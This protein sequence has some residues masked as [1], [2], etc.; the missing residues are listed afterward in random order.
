MK[1]RKFWII[2]T[3]NGAQP[4]GNLKC[5]FPQ[6]NGLCDR[7][8]AAYRHNEKAIRELGNDRFEHNRER[9][10]STN[11]AIKDVLKV[12]DKSELIKVLHGPMHREVNAL[13]Q[14]MVS[15]IN[16][17]GEVAECGEALPEVI[18][19]TYALAK[20]TMEVADGSQKEAIKKA[21]DKFDKDF[22]T[23][24]LNKTA[25]ELAQELGTTVVEAM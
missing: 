2:V 15:C 19:A 21:C 18:Q 8:L 13:T 16:E 17:R 22:R 3:T 6:W 9:L 11:R 20:A 7:L 1:T 5:D 12:E 14:L 25:S 10:R 4:N 24:Y 23:E